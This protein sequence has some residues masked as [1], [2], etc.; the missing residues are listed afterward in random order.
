MRAALLTEFKQPF[1]VEDIAYHDP[2]PGRV[3]LRTG[4]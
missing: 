4:A 2:A 1:T 3:L